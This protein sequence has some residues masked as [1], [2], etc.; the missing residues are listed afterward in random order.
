MSV[1]SEAD[2]GDEEVARSGSYAVVCAV[3][4]VVAVAYDKLASAGASGYAVVDGV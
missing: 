3:V 1:R 4:G 2:P